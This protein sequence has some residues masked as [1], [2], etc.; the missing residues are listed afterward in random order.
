MEAE[1]EELSKFCV[2]TYDMVSEVMETVD[3]TGRKTV[4]YCLGDMGCNVIAANSYQSEILD[5]LTDNMAQLESPSSKGTGNEVDM[6]QIYI[7]NP[8]VIFFAPESYFDYA[9]DDPEWQALDAIKN[10]TYYEVPYGIYNWMGFPPSV[11]RYL[12]MMWMAKILY[13]NVA[14]YDLYELVS[15][16]YSMFFHCELTKEQYLEMTENSIGK[17]EG[18]M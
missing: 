2:S 11:Q 16:F 17:L 3:E 1:A 15:E 7:W 12:G 18:Q 4:L 14:D 9:A 5:M 6:E 10:D 8:E 13:P